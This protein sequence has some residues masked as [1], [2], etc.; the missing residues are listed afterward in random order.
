MAWLRWGGA[1]SEC[2]KMVMSVQEMRTFH[3][4]R[5]SIVSAYAWWCILVVLCFFLVDSRSILIIHPTVNK[6]TSKT[7][8]SYSSDTV[9]ML[10]QRP[11]GTYSNKCLLH[12]NALLPNVEAVFF[13]FFRLTRGER[14]HTNSILTHTVNK[15]TIKTSSPGREPSHDTPKPT[16]HSY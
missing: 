10:L 7:G 8:S 11:N 13:V 6:K 1:W 9:M 14:I 5:M 2:V 12:P 15:K 16:L 3:L 4:Y